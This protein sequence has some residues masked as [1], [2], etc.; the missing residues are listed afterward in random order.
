MTDLTLRDKI[1]DLNKF[2]TGILSDAIEES[3]ID[4]EYT[5]DGK[6]VMSKPKELSREKWTQW[7]DSIYSYLKSRENSCGVPL[8]YVTRKDT[9]TSK[10]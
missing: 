10:S 1:I 2:K 7:E 8:S 9:V 3:R 4:F 6:G 5:R